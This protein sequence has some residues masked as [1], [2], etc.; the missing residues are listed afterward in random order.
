MGDLV[1]TEFVSL[2]GVMQA[3]GGEDFKYEGWSFDFERGDDGDEFKTKEIYDSEAQLLG[4]VTWESFSN[5]WPKYEEEGGEIKEFAKYFNEMDHFVVSSTLKDPEWN[6]EVIDGSGDV[7]AA[8]RKLK[9][10]VDGQ[11]LVSGSRTLVQTLLENDL[12][13]RIRLMVFPT[14]LGTGDRV[15][16]EYSNRT[17]WELV[18]AKPVG[19]DGVLTLDYRR[20]R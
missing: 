16:G 13:D 14:V 8:I 10:D 18:D 4:R 15:F 12:V 6:T 11:I 17:D 5:A 2:D 9:D 20:K 3:P 19:P 7:P 1:V